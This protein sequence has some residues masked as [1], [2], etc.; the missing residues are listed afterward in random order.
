[1][2]ALGAAF[3]SVRS[4]AGC[5]GEF[6]GLCGKASKKDKTL[7]FSND[8]QSEGKEGR[9][10]VSHIKTVQDAQGPVC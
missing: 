8:R 7:Y 5:L 10:S 2:E 3:V 9:L 1:M 6:K 4:S